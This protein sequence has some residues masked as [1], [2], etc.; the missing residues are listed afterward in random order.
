MNTFKLRYALLVVGCTLA[1]I[2]V[3]EYPTSRNL[4]T[5]IAN[6]LPLL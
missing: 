5:A 3:A 1:W 6:T 4:R 2:A